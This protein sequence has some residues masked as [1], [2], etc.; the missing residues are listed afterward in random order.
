MRTQVFE[1]KRS[2]GVQH[3]VHR[4]MCHYT[5]MWHVSRNKERRRLMRV[6]ES[7]TIFQ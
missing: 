6:I 1:I 2:S 3:K 5:E 4:K 7:R